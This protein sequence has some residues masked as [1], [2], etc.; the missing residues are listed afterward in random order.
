MNPR[1]IPHK[2]KLSAVIPCYNAGGYISA[3]IGCFLRQTLKEWEL[4]I[5][6]DGSTDN[7]LKV[8]RDHQNKDARIK[9]YQRD[10]EPKGSQT[11]RNIGL[12]KAKGEYI[13]IFDADDLISDT[14]LKSRVDFMDANPEIDYASFPAKKFKDENDLPLYKENDKAVYGVGTDDIDLLSRLL[15]T[16]YPFT[17]WANIYKRESIKEIRYIEAFGSS[18]YEDFDFM[19]S[20]VVSGLRHKFSGIREIDYYYRV[21]HGNS[22]CSKFASTP[23][24]KATNGIFSQK[25]NALKKRADYS[26]RKAE[27]KEFLLLHFE[28]I[29]ESGNRVNA[30]EYIQVLEDDYD[31]WFLN[32]LKGIAFLTLPVE[33][34]AIRKAILYFWT[35]LLFL[36]K[37]S[38]LMFGSTLKNW[39]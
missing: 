27:F 13:V 26:K 29:I 1:M 24:C 8:I 14:C 36:K 3:M 20:C 15:T 34:R 38:M 7:S 37:H 4:I 6:D 18:S 28:R 30:Y 2:I 22:M 23:Y 12:S 19:V 39:K 11:C 31:T 10:R 21:G 16:K 9:S 33:N 17:V 35:T 32:R 5:V 25:L